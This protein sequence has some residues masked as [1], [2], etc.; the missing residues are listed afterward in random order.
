MHHFAQVHV[1]GKSPKWILL[2]FV[3]IAQVVNGLLIG[4][5]GHLGNGSA[6]SELITEGKELGESESVKI[7]N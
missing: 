1:Y 4:F 7:Q 3:V 5:S 6:L 2:V